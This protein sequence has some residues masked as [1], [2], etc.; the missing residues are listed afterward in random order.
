MSEVKT[1]KISPATGTA[2]TLGDSGDTFTLP[3]GGT[4]TV[5]SGATIAN[6]GTATG[7]GSDNTPA[8]QAYRSTNQTISHDTYTKVE[9]QTEDFDTGS[10][11]DNS[12]TYL[13]T[14]PSGEG[15]VYWIYFHLDYAASVNSQGAYGALQIRVNSETNSTASFSN[16]WNLNGYAGRQMN[17]WTGGMRTLSAGDTIGFYAYGWDTGS[18]NYTIQGSAR[19]DTLVG[20][21]KMIGIS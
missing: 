11:Y 16:W 18:G 2:I 15:G 3:S 14:V 5:A 13:Y 20:A 19:R 21:Y 8:F 1:N 9:C 12:S 6:S 4:L 10:G 7:F 17:P